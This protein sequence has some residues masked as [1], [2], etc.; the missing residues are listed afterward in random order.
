MKLHEKKNFMEFE[1]LSKK[2][3]SLRQLNRIESLQFTF[4]LVNEFVYASI[5]RA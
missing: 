1:E 4:S 3:H 2:F 5:M